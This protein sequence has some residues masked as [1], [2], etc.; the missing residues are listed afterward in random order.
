MAHLA[1]EIS[2]RAYIEPAHIET[3]RN[4]KWQ[5]TSF[6]RQQRARISYHWIKRAEVELEGFKASQDY[7][8]AESWCFDVSQ[9]KVDFILAIQLGTPWQT[10][11]TKHALQG[12][13]T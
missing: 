7:K 10:I 13:A 6:V 8:A 4:K 9:N 5:K 2:H 12:E 11:V 1:C 3:K